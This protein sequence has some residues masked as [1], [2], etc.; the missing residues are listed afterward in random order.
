MV[1]AGEPP[2]APHSWN[3]M[4]TDAY[5]A[6]HPG[7]PS[8]Q[9]IQ[10]VAVH[11]LVLYGV[12]VRKASPNQALWIRQQAVREPAAV[13]HARFTWL[14]PPNFEG[15]LTIA[16]V[17]QAPTP[18]ARTTLVVEYI[19]QVWHLWSKTHLAHLEEWYNR[20]ILANL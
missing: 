1:N 4:L 19:E 5:A 12:F 9:S 14:T 15:S 13:R 8:A 3:E 10:S 18:A 17:A 20:Y 11:L 16:R 6:Q 2:L 7:V